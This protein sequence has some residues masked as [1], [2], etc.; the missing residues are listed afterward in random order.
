MRSQLFINRKS[1]AKDRSSDAE[2]IVSLRQINDEAANRYLEHV[3][4]IKQSPVSVCRSSIEV[5]G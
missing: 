3:V 5:F 1:T 4:V 2:L